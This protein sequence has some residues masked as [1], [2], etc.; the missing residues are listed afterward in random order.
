MGEEA[1]FE[2]FFV[3]ES[4]ASAPKAARAAQIAEGGYGVTTSELVDALQTS[5]GGPELVEQQ[6]SEG[7]SLEDFFAEAPTVAGGSASAA[8]SRSDATASAYAAETAEGGFG[9]TSSASAEAATA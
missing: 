1:Q 5:A 2:D 6:T 4:S 9:A 8:E 3:E 7:G